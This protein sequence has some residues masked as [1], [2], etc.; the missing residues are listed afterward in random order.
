MRLRAIM[1]GLLLVTVVWAKD[2]GFDYPTDEPD[3]NVTDQLV[4]QAVSVAGLKS[5]TG[6]KLNGRTASVKEFDQE[7]GRYLVIM[8]D[9]GEEALIKPANLVTQ[10]MAEK[11]KKASDQQAR[12]DANEAKKAAKKLEDAEIAHEAELVVNENYSPIIKAVRSGDIEATRALIAEDPDCV[13]EVDESKHQNNALHHAANRTDSA[14]LINLLLEAGKRPADALENYIS[15]VERKTMAGL[16]ALML[17]CSHSKPRACEALLEGGAEIDH[18][19]NHGYN[20]LFHAIVFHSRF[21]Q[22]NE[23]TFDLLIKH[24][25]SL[26][27]NDIYGFD[28]LVL[29]V[30]NQLQ[31]FAEKLLDA[32]CHL[33]GVTF[34]GSLFQIAAKHVMVRQRREALLFVN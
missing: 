18:Q 23:E 20:A 22:D 21:G 26:T 8:D 24:G 33:N 1:L 30:D 7:R 15:L 2:D 31:G 25:I 17:A 11:A 3:D 13:Y 16:N 29:A 27:A 19:D 32:G 6:R 14:E 12:I 5:D 34:Y 28:A 9:T 10:K 4:G